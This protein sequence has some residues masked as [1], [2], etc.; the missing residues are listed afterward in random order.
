MILDGLQNR[1]TVTL[2]N[3]LTIDVI[4]KKINHWYEKMKN[5]KEDKSKKKKLWV[6]TISS[7]KNSA[8]SVVSMATNLG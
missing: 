8:E 4:R 3:A 5:K 7:T 1:L 2:D 6:C